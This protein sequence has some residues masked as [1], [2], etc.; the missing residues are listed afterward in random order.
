MQ[1][2]EYL[3]VIGGKPQGPFF[4]D[5]LKDLE[6]SPDTF[7]KTRGM[8]DYKEAREVAELCD[9]MGFKHS[10]I[11]APQ[12]YAGIDSRL[13]AVAID[14]ILVLFV[15]VLLLIVMV[16]FVESQYLRVAFSLT[17]IPLIPV[18]KI[19]VGVFMEA[20]ERQGTFG[21]SWLGIKVTDEQGNR[22]S[23][24]RSLSR[25][26]FKIV[27][28]L[29]LGIGYLTG[30]FNRRQQCLHDIMAGTLVIKDRLV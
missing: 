21:K 14:Y 10:A 18:T 4:K 7:V 24:S 20:S 25:N 22:I 16:S 9:L 15:Y 28:V 29:T 6:I 3:V 1:E 19:I 27:P 11:P 13:L 2:D 8:A 5:Q 30:F 12:Y 26:L 17:G 23:F